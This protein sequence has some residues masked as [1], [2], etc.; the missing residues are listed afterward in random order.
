MDALWAQLVSAGSDHT[1]AGY[2]LTYPLLYGIGIIFASTP[3]YFGLGGFCFM[4]DVLDIPLFHKRRLQPK[5][6]SARSAPAMLNV[7]MQ[8]ELRD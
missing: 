1:L 8:V 7:L 6:T 4:L 3:A 5:P 2:D